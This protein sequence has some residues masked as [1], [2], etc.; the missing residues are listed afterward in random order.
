MSSSRQLD[1]NWLI[2]FDLIWLVRSYLSCSIEICWIPAMQEKVEPA[3]FFLF[4]KIDLAYLECFHCC[5]WG[6]SILKTRKMFV[7]FHSIFTI[8]RIKNRF[9]Y[10]LCFFTCTLNFFVH[11]Q[12]IPLTLY[13]QFLR[14]QSYKTL[15]IQMFLALARWK[16][17]RV[18][19]TSHVP[20]DLEYIKNETGLGA[21][22]ALTC[23]AEKPWNKQ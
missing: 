18:K 16:V 7:Y 8:V 14:H 9:L 13:A 12:Y 20:S 22:R 5:Q 10:G 6:K 4:F 3:S 23:A 11:C 15:I 2:A 1:F 17:E 19:V 21:D